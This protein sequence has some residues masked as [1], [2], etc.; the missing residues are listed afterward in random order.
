MLRIAVPGP[1][2]NKNWH[3]GKFVI[4][5]K[6]HLLGDQK[7]RA[8]VDEAAG[9]VNGCNEIAG[10][11]SAVLDAKQVVAAMPLEPLMTYSQCVP[12]AGWNDFAAWNSATSGSSEIKPAGDGA[13]WSLD[14]I[15]AHVNIAFSVVAVER[16]D[17]GASSG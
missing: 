10:G 8:A 5:L 16:L 14:I 3:N 15:K 9:V 7:S 2:Q 17:I 11:A 4:G 1:L 13:A 6:K 12:I